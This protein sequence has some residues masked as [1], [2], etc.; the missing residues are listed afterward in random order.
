MTQEPNRDPITEA[1][2]ADLERLTYQIDK[3]R[4][5]SG[6]A[7][8]NFVSEKETALIQARAAVIQAIAANDHNLTLAAK[9]DELIE[10]LRDVVYG[11][12]GLMQQR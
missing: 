7:H 3:E 8:K 2:V 10:P 6:G 11:E 9:L 4:T 1:L 12:R 5:T